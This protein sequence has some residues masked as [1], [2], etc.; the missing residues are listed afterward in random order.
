MGETIRAEYRGK[1]VGTVHS[2]WAVGWGAAAIAY[3]LLFR[4]LPPALAWRAMFWIGVLPGFLVLYIRRNIPEPDVYFT[5]RKQLEAKGASSR[6]LEIFSP[7]VLKTTVLTSLVSLG[8]QGGIWPL[9]V[10]LPTYLRTVRKL[11]VLNTGGYLFV[12]ITGSFIGFLTAAHLADIL[13]RKKTIILF[14]VCCFFTVFCY[15]YLP[16]SNSAMLLLG[17]P[18]GF[19]AQGVFAP[20]GAFFTELYP[21]RL[22]GSGQGFCFNFGRG[23]SA[24]FPMF[25]G[26][27]SVRIGLAKAI[28]V[29]APTAYVVLIIAVAMLPETKGKQLKALE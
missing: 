28:C 2:A 17:F 18:L 14:A 22:R 27:L 29:F 1:A 3:M 23:L 20:M 11:S 21:T 16:I 25:V 8:A 5:T 7:S 6:S 15:L 4:F 19:F 10:W 13:G 12:L 24:L 26:F 9:N